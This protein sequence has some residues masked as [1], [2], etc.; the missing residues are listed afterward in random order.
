[1]LWETGLHQEIYFAPGIENAFYNWQDI[2]IFDECFTKYNENT[3]AY[4]YSSCYDVLSKLL[5]AVGATVFQHNGRWFIVGF[6]RNGNSLDTYRVYN[7]YGVYM[8][9]KQVVRTLKNPKF[10]KGLGVNMASP[11]KTVQLNVSYQES[12]NAVDFSKLYKNE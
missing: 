12:K 2:Q 9:N 11:N 3:D 6:N 4:N 8:Y 10:N 5:K 1:C 7:P